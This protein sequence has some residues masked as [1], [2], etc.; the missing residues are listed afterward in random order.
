MSKLKA[1]LPQL[2]GLALVIGGGFFM[3]VELS[4]DREATHIKMIAG[5]IGAGLLLVVP[6]QLASG[7]KEVGSA[8]ADAWK[9]KNAA[10]K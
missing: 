4:S 7:I 2:L 6:K 3:R 8:L 1:A 9:A 5:L 10:E